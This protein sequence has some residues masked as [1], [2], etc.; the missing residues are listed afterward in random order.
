MPLQNWTDGDADE[1]ITYNVHNGLDAWRKLYHN[2]L[3][4][5]DRQA[6]QPTDESTALRPATSL[7]DMRNKIQIID[8]TTSRINGLQGYPFPEKLKVSKLKMVVPAD[9][10]SHLTIHSD[11]IDKY[12]EPIQLIEPQIRDRV[13]GLSKGGKAPVLNTTTDDDTIP[14][15]ADIE[16]HLLESGHKG[17]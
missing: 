11:K 15:Q 6:T 17:T 1:V 10:S 16:R 7:A 14:E 5:V 3:T 2:E 12:E 9:T 13:A 4:D 8:R